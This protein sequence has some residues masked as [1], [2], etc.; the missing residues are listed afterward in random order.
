[1]IEL[2]GRTMHRLW[3]LLNAPAMVDGGRGSLD[4]GAL[5]EDDRR[6]R[7]RSRTGR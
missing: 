1:M 2:A 3:M 7:A 6:L 5:T 4:G